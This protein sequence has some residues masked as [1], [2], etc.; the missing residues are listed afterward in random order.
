M[1]RSIFT[2]VL[3][4]VLLPFALGW[5]TTREDDS[6][7]ISADE[8]RTMLK[9]MKMEFK[10]SKDEED[11]TLFEISK[12]DDTIL[13][14][15]YGGEGDKGSSVQLRATFEVE[16]EDLEMLNNWN[17]SRRYTKCYSDG[18]GSAMLEQDLDL[19]AGFE[20]SQLKK[21]IGDFIKTVP[22][23]ADELAGKE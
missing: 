4:A 15:Q 19:E 14:F 3:P 17:Y 23:F 10:E 16:D 18:D 11:K 13:L 22:E 8:I 5:V 21:F 20:K 9:D 2:A 7:Y 1:K 6:K 12:D